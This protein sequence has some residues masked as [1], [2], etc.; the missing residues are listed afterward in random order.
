MLGF[1]FNRVG[2]TRISG[3]GLV[4]AIGHDVGEASLCVAGHI[5]VFCIGNLFLLPV[6]SYE[7]INIV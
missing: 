3:A 6:S 7:L 5:M 2:F 1:S 4:W